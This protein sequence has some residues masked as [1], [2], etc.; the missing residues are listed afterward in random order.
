MAD[1]SESPEYGLVMPFVVCKTNGGVYDDAAFVAGVR[2]GDLWTRVKAGEAIIE[3]VEPPALV[4]Q[5]DL[6]AMRDGYSLEVQPWSE[7]PDEWAFVT[8]RKLAPIGGDA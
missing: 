4:P 1:S 5:I 3:T 2:Y 8:L 7:A 6:L